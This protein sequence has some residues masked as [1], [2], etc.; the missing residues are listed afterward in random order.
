MGPGR[1]VEFEMLEV[2]DEILED[3][4]Q[5]SKASASRIAAKIEKFEQEYMNSRIDADISAGFDFKS[6]NGLPGQF[7][8]C[9]VRTTSDY[10]A[11]VMFPYDQSRAYW[12]HLWKKTKLNNRRQTELAEDR[13]KKAYPQIKGRQP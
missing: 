1:L 11:A 13:A 4:R 8:L 2:F 7:R 9:Q 3:L 5:S 6:L 12:V 10:R